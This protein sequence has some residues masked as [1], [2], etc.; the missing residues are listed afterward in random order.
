MLR[1]LKEGTERPSNTLLYPKEGTALIN[2]RAAT[3]TEVADQTCYLIQSQYTNT[4]PTSP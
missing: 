1:Y 3:L 2:V 4:G